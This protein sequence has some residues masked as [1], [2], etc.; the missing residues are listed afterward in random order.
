MCQDFCNG[1]GGGSKAEG[2]GDWCRCSEAGIAVEAQVTARFRF[3]ADGA[4]G[5]GKPGVLGAEDSAKAERGLGVLGRE[6]V[7]LSQFLANETEKAVVGGEGKIIGTDS[8]GVSLASGTSRYDEREFAITTS[9]DE[10]RFLFHIINRI[11]DAV[12]VAAQNVVGIFFGEEGDLFMND[13][14]GIDQLES[15]GHGVNLETPDVSIVSR[16]LAVHIGDA[17][18]IKIDQSDVTDTAAGDCFRSPGADSTDSDHRDVRVQQARE[19]FGSVESGDAGKPVEIFGWEF[20]A[21]RTGTL[22]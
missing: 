12:E 1:L 22:R 5:P 10:E 8:G 18:L 19:R 21:H 15:L 14:L 3:F 11:D 17:D 20:F 7:V 4:V 2:A 6:V 9:G 16:E 13:D